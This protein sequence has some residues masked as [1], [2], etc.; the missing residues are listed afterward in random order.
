MHEYYNIDNDLKLITLASMLA[1]MKKV[2]QLAILMR[3]E[4]KGNSQ[5]Q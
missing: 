3:S 5:F 1:L 4:K 2:G